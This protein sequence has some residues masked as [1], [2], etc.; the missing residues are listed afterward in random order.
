MG[1]IAGLV[2]EGVALNEA[3]RRSVPKSRRSWVFRHWASF[4]RDGFEALIDERL[5][6]EAST[7]P[8]YENLVEVAREANSRVTVEEVLTILEKQGVR[9][10]P[11]EARVRRCFRRVDARKRH[12]EKKSAEVE[13]IELPLAGG[14]LLLAAEIETGAI[15]ALTDVVEAIGAKAHE[16]SV[17]K[18]HT[19]DVARRDKLGHFTRRYNEHR[20]RSAGEEVASYLRPAAEKALG[21]VPNWARFTHE[22]RETLEPKLL[23]MTFAP[24]VCETKGWDALR[25]ERAAGLAPLTGFAYMP[26]TLAKLTSALAIAGAGPQLLEGMALNWHRVAEATWGE[27]GAAAALYVDNHVKEVWSSLFTMSGKVSHLSRV[28]PCITTTYVHTGAGTPM[29]VSVQSGSAPLAPRLIDLVDDVERKLG[30]DVRRAV[31]IDAEGSTFDIL[32]T[33]SKRGRVIVTPLRP[34]RAPELELV[35]SRGSY[36]RPYRDHDELRVAKATLI[37]KSSGRSLPIGALLIRRDHRETD[38]ILLTTGLALGLECGD[39]AD[40]YYSRWPIQEN[41]FKDGRTVDLVE[42]RGNC[43]RMVANIAVETELE[44]LSRREKADGPKLAELEAARG[45]HADAVAAARLEHRR[46]TS[47]LTTRRRRLDGLVDDGRESGRMLG[48]A[49][50]EHRDALVLEETTGR[51]LAKAERTLQAA[52]TKRE[53]LESSL[54]KIGQRRATLEPKQRI[55]EIDV[56]QDTIL[57]ATKLTLSLLITF[58]LREYL[59]SLAMSP[60]TF[61]SRIFGFS[62]RREVHATEE[63]VI[64]YENPRDPAANQAVA[65]AC[66][67]LNERKLRREKRLLFYWTEKRD[68]T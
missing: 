27:P 48:K 50:I 63:H 64:F 19:P 67:R 37:H 15:G 18:K 66:R 61:A 13:I 49:A 54:T 32:E 40:L 46:A 22:R 31:V 10:L 42:H 29:V 59:S 14:E 60:D 20:R 3:I 7:F 6:R 39:L 33:F 21:R 52:E 9:V 55:R 16:A 41:S 34:A 62:G 58:V 44:R 24:L 38:T 11:T 28:M 25:S 53:K 4:R 2:G 8:A 51:T 43:G 23:T 56:A 35:Y 45:G 1:T 68:G 36:Y 65:E 17:G 57:T 26:S 30:G 12:G 47:A 5:P